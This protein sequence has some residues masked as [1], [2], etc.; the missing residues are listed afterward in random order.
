VE[1]TLEIHV[2]EEYAIK[3]SHELNKVNAYE[4]G[5]YEDQTFKLFYTEKKK[6]Y[7]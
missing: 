2:P 3:L 1:G 5:G 4:V 6:N 7:I